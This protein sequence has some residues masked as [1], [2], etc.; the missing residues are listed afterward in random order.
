MV[1]VVIVIG[2][3]QKIDYFELMIK[4]N[5]DFMKTQSPRYLDFRSYERME[6]QEYV[7]DHLEEQSQ[8]QKNLKQVD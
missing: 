3:G 8:K 5:S 2:M 1:M 6:Y 4:K 7:D